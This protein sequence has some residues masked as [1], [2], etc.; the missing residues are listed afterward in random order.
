[1]AHRCGSLAVDG[2]TLIGLVLVHCLLSLAWL[3]RYAA[4]LLRA[5]GFLQRPRIRQAWSG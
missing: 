2:L 5:S 1:M 4:L 3:F